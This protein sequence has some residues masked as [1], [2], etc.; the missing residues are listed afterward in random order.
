MA[1]KRATDEHPNGTATVAPPQIPVETAPPVPEQTTPEP[2]ANRPVFKVGPIPTDK[3]NSVEVAVWAREVT[4]GDRTFTVYNYPAYLYKKLLK[5]FGEKYG[6]ET[7][8]TAFDNISS[9]I[10][11]LAS[12][13]H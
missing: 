12:G 6:V 4:S 9:G 10:Q 13:E 11:R 3:D 7:Q 5:E 2:A 1:R 8:L